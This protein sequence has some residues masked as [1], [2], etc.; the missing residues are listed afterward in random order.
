MNRKIKTLRLAGIFCALLLLWGCQSSQTETTAQYIGI[1]AA[2]EAALTDAGLSSQQAVFSD[3]GLDN[4][5]GTFYYQIRFTADGKKYQYAIDALTGVVIE[6]Q[7]EIESPEASEASAETEALSKQPSSAA[8]SS[9]AS[10]G[11]ADSS[12]MISQ[13]TAL[14]TALAHAGITQDQA[15]KIEIQRDYDHGTAVYEIEFYGENWEEYSYH[16]DASTGEIISYDYD[17]NDSIQQTTDASQAMLTEDQIREIVLERVPTASSDHI[18][19]RLDEDDGRMEYEGKLM[20]EDMEYE[21]KIDAYS[22]SVTEWEAEKR[23]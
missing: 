20:E 22:G 14:E 18:F 6:V 2:K 11:T 23:P 17:Q 13:E 9:S 7:T 21:F 19:L 4:R 5:D 10:A 16:I 1:D 3:S 15:K 12:G 8:P